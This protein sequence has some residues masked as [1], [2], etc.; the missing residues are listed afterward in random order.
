MKTNR[1]WISIMV[2]VVSFLSCK[3]KSVR[4]A[5][6]KGEQMIPASVKFMSEIKNELGFLPEAIYSINIKSIINSPFMK[7]LQNQFTKL[8]TNSKCLMSVLEKTQY[9]HIFS[10]NQE[11]IRTNE[12]PKKMALNEILV[13]YGVDSIAAQKCFANHFPDML[14]AKSGDKLKTLPGTGYMWS[15]SRDILVTAP[16]SLIGKLIPGKG[17]LGS[18]KLDFLKQK[19]SV[20][21]YFN[22]GKSFEKGA[23]FIDFSKGL[24]TDVFL[25][26][27]REL[28]ARVAQNQYKNMKRFFGANK[29]Y[30][31]LLDNL[32]FYK[33]EK[34]VA[35]SFTQTRFQLRQLMG[36]F[37]L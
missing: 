2:V 26:Y 30:S 24:D 3:K 25:I 29:K 23:G 1:L 31:K 4:T 34:T 8:S 37:G 6:L 21:F 5:G 27:K 9:L 36:I 20:V 7:I 10:R 28:L 35:F 11:F 14:L 13:F 16:M 17:K 32:D 19:P 33:N 18:G 15:P 12:D 22:Q